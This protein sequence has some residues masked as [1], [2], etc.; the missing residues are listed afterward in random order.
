MDRETWWA[1]VNGVTEA[2]TTELLSTLLL[3]RFWGST[4]KGFLVLTII[5]ANI[6][7]TLCARISFK[8][9]KCM[10]CY[11]CLSLSSKEKVK[12]SEYIT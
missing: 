9:F 3:S 8:H 1:T 2:D 11:V 10:C 5:T 12:L 7:Y 6:Y 4:L